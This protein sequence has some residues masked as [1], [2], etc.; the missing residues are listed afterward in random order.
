MAWSPR[1]GKEGNQPAVT[2]TDLNHVNGPEPRKRTR[3]RETTQA[4][5]RRP[6]PLLLD[7]PIGAERKEFGDD[8]T[9]KHSATTAPGNVA[10]CYVSANCEKEMCRGRTKKVNH[11]TGETSKALHL[12]ELR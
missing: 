4:G 5:S 7:E 10:K 11:D 8:S 12:S 6:S 3:T 1:R 2:Q 9:V